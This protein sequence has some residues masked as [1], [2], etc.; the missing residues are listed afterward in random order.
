MVVGAV[1]IPINPDALPAAAPIK[2]LSSP[3]VTLA[4]AFSPINVLSEPFILL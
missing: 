3:E 1:P 4:P 2:V